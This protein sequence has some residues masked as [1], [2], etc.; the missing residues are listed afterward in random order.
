EAGSLAIRSVAEIAKDLHDRFTDLQYIFPINVAKRECEEG[1]RLLGAWR[2]S[3]ASAHQD[4]VAYKAAGG[5][6]GKEPEV[7]GVNVGEIIAGQGERRLELSR[8]IR[9]S[10]KRLTRIV[11]RCYDLRRS[12]RR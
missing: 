10:V 3:Q 12:S 7:V 9:S 2:S 11:A 6:D 5:D 4:V 8:Q 1:K